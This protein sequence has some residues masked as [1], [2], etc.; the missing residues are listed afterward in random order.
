M[1]FGDTVALVNRTSKV[2]SAQWDGAHYHFEPGETPNVPLDIASAAFRQNPLMGSEDPLGDPNL[3]PS[4]FGIKGAREPYGDCS[5]LEQSAAGE[6]LDRSK[7]AHSGR[8]AKKINAGGPS[9]FEARM[10]SDNVNL[11][12]DAEARR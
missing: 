10:G 11:Q 5:P 2:L 8:S 3:I 4:L 1:Q 7:M 12:D 9:H 6:R